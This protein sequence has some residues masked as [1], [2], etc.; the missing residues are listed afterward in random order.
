MINSKKIFFKYYTKLQ[1]NPGMMSLF[2]LEHFNS[3]SV[4]IIAH[5][6]LIELNWFFNIDRIPIF[7]VII[8]IIQLILRLLRTVIIVCLFCMC[9][10][11]FMV[12]HLGIMA[13]IA[14]MRT[15]TRWFTPCLTIFPQDIIIANCFLSNK[16]KILCDRVSKS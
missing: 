9:C 10:F 4:F 12:L 15:T 3:C 14:F 5:Q 8:V 1:K 2:C 13:S 6:N 11:C 7:L 16:S